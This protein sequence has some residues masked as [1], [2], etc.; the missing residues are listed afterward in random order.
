MNAKHAIAALDDIQ[1]KKRVTVP[2]RTTFRQAIDGVRALTQSAG[3]PYLM[4]DLDKALND[5]E[6]GLVS[7]IDQG[8][9][10]TVPHRIVLHKLYGG[11][12]WSTHMQNVNDG[13]FHY[14]HYFHED[15]DAALEDFIKRCR[16]HKPE[17][18][19]TQ[20]ESQIIN[21]TL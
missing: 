9:D 13:S 16:E 7:S 10:A 17:P 20:L 21:N 19:F 5:A 8:D 15:F 6:K 11:K 12:E 4:G 1:A 18:L 14:G 2:K 3:L